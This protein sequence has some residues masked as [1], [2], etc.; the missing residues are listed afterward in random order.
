MNEA[1]GITVML[2]NYVHDVATGLLLLSALWLAWSSRDLGAAPS[3]ETV[4]VFRTSYR[5]CVRFV[6]GSIL[7]IIATGAVR[8][9]F[10][11]EFEWHPALGRAL[12]GVL[13]VK[14]VLIFT[15]LG[16]GAY[17]WWG[18]KRRLRALPGWG[19]PT[20]GAGIG[21]VVSPAPGAVTRELP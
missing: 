9:W 13:L 2:N 6:L 18:L 14:H 3:P 15:M 7:F 10:F 21:E 4:A 16:V 20:A 5:R 17:A 12:V 8:A 11:V 19:L 1:L